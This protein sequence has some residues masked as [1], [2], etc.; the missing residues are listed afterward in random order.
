LNVTTRVK[1]TREI[2][3]R[4]SGD[5]RCTE[6]GPPHGHRERRKTVERRLPTV[7]EGVITEAEWFR[8]MTL[9]KAKRLADERLRFEL[10]GIYP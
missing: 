7:E 9:Y 1:G 3:R 2:K 8:H 10:L 6:N 5:R 4:G